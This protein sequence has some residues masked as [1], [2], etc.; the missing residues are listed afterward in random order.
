MTQ[1]FTNQPEAETT[2]PRLTPEEYAQKKQA[3]REGVYMLADIAAA[4]IIQSPENFRIFLNVQSQMDRYSTTNALLIYKQFPRATQLKEFSDWAAEN[5]RVTK[6]EKSILILEPSEYVKKDGSQ[7]IGFQVKKVFDILQTNGRR[8]PAQ[9]RLASPW[10]LAEAM[11]QASPVSV[12]MVDG[13]SDP[14]RTVFYS[15]SD[16]ALFLKRDVDRDIAFCQKLSRELGRASLPPLAAVGS[17]K[18]Q[19]FQVECV[20]YLFCRKYGVD[21]RCFAV[22][23]I[24]EGWKQMDARGLRGKLSETR[25][26]FSELHS[27]T[28][29]NLYRNRQERQMTQERQGGREER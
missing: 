15:E 12:Q 2:R 4:E 27:R 23:E 24:P 1:S 21:T 5:V 18:E 25:S 7:G 14:D 6:G 8:K 19:D 28:F 11:L 22:G 3:E 17:R 16:Q 10:E 20:G 26:A 29:E 13:F 9:H